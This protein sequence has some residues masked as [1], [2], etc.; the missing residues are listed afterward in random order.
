M[1]VCNFRMYTF[2]DVKDKEMKRKPIIEPSFSVDHTIILHFD[3]V[4]G[5][6]EEEKAAKRKML[7][8]KP[9]LYQKISFEDM[10]SVVV[11]GEWILTKQGIYGKGRERKGEEVSGAVHSPLFQSPLNKND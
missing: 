4:H 9:K 7:K 5:K 1:L 10:C 2:V 8:R 3:S 11:T 6:S